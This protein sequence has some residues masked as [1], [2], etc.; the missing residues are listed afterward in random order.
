MNSI[1]LVAFLIYLA[2]F[3][4]IGVLDFKKI[5]TFDDYGVAGKNY[6]SAH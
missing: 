5:K 1:F 2:V 6:C 3:I 4:V